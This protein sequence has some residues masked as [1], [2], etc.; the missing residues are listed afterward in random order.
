MHNRTNH[1]EKTSSKP[2]TIQKT[3]K[4]IVLTTYG[5]FGDLHPYM[6]IALE[7]KSRGHRAV[8]ATSEIYHHKIEAEGIEF[9][10]VRPNGLINTEQEGAFLKLLVDCQRG[11]EYIINYQLMPH[12]RASYSD[13]MDA[14][15][16]ADLLLTHHLAFAGSLVAEKTGIPWVSSVLSP[17]LFMSA[18]DSPS[19]STLPVS[20]YE[21]ALEQVAND[22]RIRHF[23]WSARLW[24]APVRQL[25]AELG[26]QPGYNP[27]FEGQHSPNLVLALFSQVFTSSQPD[28]CPQT[29]VTGFPFYDRQNREGLSPELVNF[30]ESGAPPIVFTLGSLMVW[31][32]GNFYLEGAIAAQKLGYRAILLMG[33]GVHHL[34]VEELPAGV[35]AVDYASHAKIFPRAAAIVH[36]GGVGTTG[37]ALR[38]GRPML[39]VPYAHDQPDNAVRLV[40]L[41]VARMLERHQYTADRVASE[42]KHLLCN[43]SY[44]ARSTEVGDQIRAEDG[45]GVACDAIETYLDASVPTQLNS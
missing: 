3:R 40:R 38:S 21:R 4:H 36:H 42:L 24:S 19:V 43:P 13:L 29:C 6:A 32:P 30:L 9:H 16:G 18:Y 26:L 39:V 27:I 11:S 23:Q 37:Q 44:T 15:Y 20:S 17:I 2:K 34:P 31:T 28:W 22:S 10:A 25:R 33:Q 12:L 5:S 1:K 45:V 41:G 7:L 8:I 14:V 35:L